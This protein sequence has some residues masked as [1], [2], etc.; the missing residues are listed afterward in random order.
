[1]LINCSMPCYRTVIWDIITYDSIEKKQD[2][3]PVYENDAI[4]HVSL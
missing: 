4:E 2:R 3:F 1:M